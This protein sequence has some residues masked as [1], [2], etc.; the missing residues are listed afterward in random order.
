MKKRILEFKNGRI[1]CLEIGG[2]N[3][4]IENLSIGQFFNLMLKDKSINY[5]HN[6]GIQG[7]SITPFLLKRGFVHTNDYAVKLNTFH[8][9]ESEDGS[10]HNIRVN[11]QHEIIDFYDSKKILNFKVENLK[12]EFL[13]IEGE[14][15]DLEIISLSLQKM[16]NLGH[17]NN[18][19]SANAWSFYTKQKFQKNDKYSRSLM[20]NYY[21]EL[22]IQFDDFI[23]ESY[24]GG[25]VYLEELHEYLPKSGVTLDVNS[26]FPYV[27][28]SQILP[29]GQPISFSGEYKEDKR[30][31]LYIQQVKFDWIKLKDNKVPFAITSGMSKLIEVDYIKDVKVDAIMTVTNI[32]FEL[33]KECYEFG[34]I[35]YGNGLKFKGSINLFKEY[36]SYFKNIKENSVGTERQIAKLFLNTLYG[37][38]GT[39]VKRQTYDYVL[40]NN[41]VERKI[42]NFN[43]VESTM[44]YT[45]MASFITSYARAIT[46]KAANNN[47][48]NFIYSDTDSIH[49]SCP[50]SEVKGIEI[51][52]KKFGSWKLEKE[53]V[54]SVFLGLKCYGEK[55]ENGWEFKIAGLPQ[56]A[57]KNL[58]INDFY[59]GNKINCKVKTKTSNGVEIIEREFT[60]C[61]NKIGKI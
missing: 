30:Y 58:D 42:I 1:N 25:W 22:P 54:D 28:E 33:I 40:D 31:P 5:F 14:Y 6:L 8:K 51:D 2:Q 49:L 24:K 60:I 36:I 61:S 38:F 16:F 50:I 12:N 47:Y 52:D 29:Y 44:Y 23:R 13:Q 53:F 10:I 32:E 7:G 21:P 56:E 39:K 17:T 43:K 26:L 3:Q 11:Y 57:I 18:S 15:S 41:G 20:R 48:D 59:I 46:I 34:N 55:D 37:K 9:I 4:Y 35:T 27:M 45:A 19:M